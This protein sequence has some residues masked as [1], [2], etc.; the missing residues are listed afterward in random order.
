MCQF[1]TRKTAL[2]CN[3]HFREKLNWAEDNFFPYN[4]AGLG[5]ILLLLLHHT[6]GVIDPWLIF[7]F[8]NWLVLTEAWKVAKIVFIPKKKSVSEDQGFSTEFPYLKV[9]AFVHEI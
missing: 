7:F 8:K 2:C 4:F 1:C 6:K 5:G 3:F 9:Q